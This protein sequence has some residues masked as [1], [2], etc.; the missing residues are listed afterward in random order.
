MGTVNILEACRVTPSVKTIVMITSDK[1]YENMEWVWGYR[2][3]DRLGG[4]DPYSA[5][6][7]ASELVCSA[8]R[9]SFFHL[10]N[11]EQHGKSLSTVRA[12]NVIGGGDWAE[13]RIV[14]DCIKSLEKD[15]PIIV[16]NPLATRPWQHVL[17]PLGGYLWLAQKMMQQP[18]AFSESWNFGPRSES[19]IPVKDLVEYII[20]F[21]GKGEWVD[22]SG[23]SVLH[24]AQLLAL[25]ITKA[26][27]RL[28]WKPV[29]TFPQTI[30]MTVDWYK[31]YSAE[32]TMSL[33]I[34]QIYKYMDLWKSRN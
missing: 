10:D 20:K 5:S 19:I 9:R 17:E 3:N 25:D 27:H 7:G 32:S 21:Y 1:C 30:E 4:F 2:E 6:K 18:K 22:L 11:F 23:N 15:K 24:E 12:G 26:N 29:L 8:Y 33:C 28:N 34:E 31:R 14:P 13:N 16:R